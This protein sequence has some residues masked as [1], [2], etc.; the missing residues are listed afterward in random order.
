MQVSKSD[1]KIINF[2][3]WCYNRWKSDN[4]E[5]LID[6][7]F[8]LVVHYRWLD[9]WISCIELW[10]NEWISM[11]FTRWNLYPTNILQFL[12]LQQKMAT[13]NS[14]WTYLGFWIW[15]FVELF[16]KISI[17]FNKFLARGK[18][19]SLSLVGSCLLPYYLLQTCIRSLQHGTGRKSWMWHCCQTRYCSKDHY[20]SSRSA[21]RFGKLHY[22][23]SIYIL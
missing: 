14:Y 9:F 13:S 16:P 2:S 22:F 20:Y 18:L 19:F 4:S 10:T 23:K 8:F 15:N 21:H 5:L 17:T 6:E 7:I 11:M 12:E 1:T 3:Q